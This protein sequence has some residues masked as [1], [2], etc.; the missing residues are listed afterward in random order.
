MGGWTR[1]GGTVCH[2]GGRVDFTL[3]FDSSPIK[4]E[5]YMVGVV[6]FTRVTL[7]PCGYPHYAGMTGRCGWFGLFA[8]APVSGTGTGFGPLPSRERGRMVGVVL[9]S[10]RPVDTALK[11][12]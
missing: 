9:L 1:G 6:L 11:S 8:L 10:P 4:G 3:T 12:A 5:G 2:M 7:P